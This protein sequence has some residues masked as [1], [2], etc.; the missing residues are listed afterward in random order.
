MVR[1][2]GLHRLDGVRTSKDYF[3]IHS[4]SVG[5][6]LSLVQGDSRLLTQKEI[7]LF[8]NTLS[9]WWAQP[10]LFTFR[11]LISAAYKTEL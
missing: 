10:S 4:V 5:R 2:E 3:E 6:L 8:G 7:E 1:K 9:N 11:A